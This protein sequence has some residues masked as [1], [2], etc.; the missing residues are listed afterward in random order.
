M[1]IQKEMRR[2]RVIQLSIRGAVVWR[3][4]CAHHDVRMIDVLFVVL[5]LGRRG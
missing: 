4:G 2:N 5:A 1:V 3:S